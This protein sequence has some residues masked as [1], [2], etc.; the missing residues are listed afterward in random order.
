M[1]S[2]HLPSTCCNSRPEHEHLV[3]DEA[4]MELSACIA[5]WRVLGNGALTAEHPQETIC[6]LRHRGKRELSS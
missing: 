2:S 4:Q 5:R 3:M 6:C 1:G